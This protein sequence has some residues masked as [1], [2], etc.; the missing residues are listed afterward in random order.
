MRNAILRMTLNVF[1][2]ISAPS[3][4]PSGLTPIFPGATSITL[5]WRHVSSVGQNGVILGYKVNGLLH[6][7][8]IVSNFYVPVYNYNFFAISVYRKIELRI[9]FMHSY[10]TQG[11]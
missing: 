7:T 4:A 9:S 11:L 10:K 6:S 8:S 1:V 2:C 3:A 5:R